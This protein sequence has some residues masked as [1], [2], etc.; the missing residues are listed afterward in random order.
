MFISKKANYLDCLTCNSCVGE[1]VYKVYKYKSKKEL[2]GGLEGE[3]EAKLSK[4]F[5]YSM[6]QNNPIS[7]L[8]EGLQE[9]EGGEND[10]NQSRNMTSKK[11]QSSK[12]QVTPANNQFKINNRPHLSSH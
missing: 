11:Y 4:P 8:S 1:N 9:Y 2:N 3:E 7:K 12:A 5:V 6:W 10:N